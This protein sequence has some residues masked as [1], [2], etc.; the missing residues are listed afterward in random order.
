MACARIQITA[1]LLSVPPHPP[2]FQTA[3]AFLQQLSQRLTLRSYLVGHAPSAADWAAWGSLKTNPVAQGVI[4]GGQVPHVKRWYAHLS[5]L[6]AAVKADE[7]IKTQA[8][9]KPASAPAAGGKAKDKEPEANATFELGLP[10]AVKGHVV[11]RLPP[12]PS[13]YL[14]IGHAKAAVLNQYF[15]RM[16]EGKFLI[17][18][19]DTNPSKEKVIARAL[20]FQSGVIV[21]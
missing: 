8:K 1:L 10:N 21:G 18:F 19:D 16:Y 5:A 14:H 15:A 13:G 11:T 9:V 12:E 17:R 6:E 7:E 20:C 3:I 2:A 4:Q